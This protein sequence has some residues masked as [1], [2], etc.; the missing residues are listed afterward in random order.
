MK[1][2]KPSKSKKQVPIVQDD[3]Y[4]V[5]PGQVRR[6]VGDVFMYGRD[7]YVVE[8]VTPSRAVARCLSRNRQTPVEPEVDPLAE[9]PEKKSSSSS[10]GTISIS[11]CCD[12]Q[13]VIDRVVP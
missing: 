2:P 5:P 12:W 3:S 1:K 6:R 9:S 4:D 13:D 10:S 7:K 8:S 11:S